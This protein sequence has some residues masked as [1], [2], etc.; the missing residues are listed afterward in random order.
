MRRFNLHVGQQ[1]Q[2]RGTVFP[3]YV[4]LTIVGQ[5]A[6]GPSPSFLIFRRDYFEVAAGRPGIVDNF[7]VRVVGSAAS[8]S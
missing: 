4:A 6:R 7:W 1:I 3:F 8:S 5:I 2:I